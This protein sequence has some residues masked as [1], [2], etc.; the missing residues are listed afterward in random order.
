[1]H[2]KHGTQRSQATDL[3]LHSK[4][5][6]GSAVGSASRLPHTHF[7][8]LSNLSW[9]LIQVCKTEHTDQTLYVMCSPVRGVSG[10]LGVPRE[11]ITPADRCK[12]CGGTHPCP[13]R[14]PAEPSLALNWVGRERLP[15]AAE[16]CMGHTGR[17]H[18][19]PRLPGGVGGQE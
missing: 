13:L 15:E 6:P 14:P 9:I 1:M 11:P 5:L 12:G 3:R 17:I 19:Q 10:R 2:G 18:T 16:G 7:H 4:L 8:S